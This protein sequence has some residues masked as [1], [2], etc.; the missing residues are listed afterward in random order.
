MPIY[1]NV[2]KGKCSLGKIHPKL[3][4]ESF[5]LLLKMDVIGIINKI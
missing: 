1:D 4:K 3:I 2:G 5:F